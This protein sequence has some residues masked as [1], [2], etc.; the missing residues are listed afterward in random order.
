MTADKEVNKMSIVELYFAL[1]LEHAE[2]K[3]TINGV[4]MTWAQALLTYGDCR[5]IILS[6]EIIEGIVYYI[7]FC[8]R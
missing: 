2:K 3:V 8:K 7:I 1:D 4:R 6:H 5:L